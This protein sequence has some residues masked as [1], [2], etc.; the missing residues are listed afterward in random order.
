MLHP[1]ILLYVIQIDVPAGISIPMRSSQNASTSKLKC[2]IFGQVVSVFCI[3]DAIGECLARTDTE[4]ISGKAGAVAVDVVE[5]GAFERCHAS[6]HGSLTVV[7]S[8]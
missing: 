1:P 4:E 6:A 5:G 8:S 2:F 3:E 7:V